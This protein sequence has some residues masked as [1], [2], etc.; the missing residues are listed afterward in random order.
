MALKPREYRSKIE[1]YSA[2]TLLKMLDVMTTPLRTLKV[3][4]IISSGADEAEVVERLDDL[5]R[6]EQ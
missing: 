3:C 6:E 1:S 2:E 5:A 4:E